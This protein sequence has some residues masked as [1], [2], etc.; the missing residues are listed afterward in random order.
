MTTL[1][2]HT[3]T[4]WCRDD[5]RTALPTPSTRPSHAVVLGAGGVSAWALHFGVADALA[6]AGLGLAEATTVIGTSAGAAV[7]AS[8]LGGTTTDQALTEV[9][10][11]PPPEERRAY[12]AEV[13]QHN[14][15]RSWLAAQP[16]LLSH[17][18]P[19]RG[20]PGVAWAG[21][22]P[23]GIFPSSSLT[24]FPGLAA[25]EEWP[26][27]LRVV[28]VRLSDG[29]R[30]VFGRDRADVD[31]ATAVRASQSV[32]LL[33]APTAVGDE[34]FVDGAV[35]SSTH[36]DLVLDTDCDLTVVVAPMCRRG[37]GAARSLARRAAREELLAL[38]RAGM[39]AVAIRPGPDAE[40]LFRGYRTDPAA[41]GRMVD[42]GRR[43][44]TNALREAGI[45]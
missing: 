23:A 29:A 22:S 24:R 9:L 27:A 13:R 17:L 44:V 21:L 28:A 39:R 35:R 10:R 31:V 26:A 38:R 32:P 30:V 1:R 42:A 36:A 12:L 6:E 41:P 18:L 11:P 15:R 19:G 40:H 20:G 2:R 43:M 5:Q 7:A 37:G 14:R 45:S 4:V 8:V 25:H 34:R 16:R 3:T 33:F